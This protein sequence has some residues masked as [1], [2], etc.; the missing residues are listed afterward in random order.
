MI[1]KNKRMH[2]YFCGFCNKFSY[3]SD[4]IQGKQCSTCKRPTALNPTTQQVKAIREIY[5]IIN[6]AKQ[7]EEAN[8]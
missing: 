2:Q 8:D 5:E 6:K 1:K 4:A 7:K 3:S